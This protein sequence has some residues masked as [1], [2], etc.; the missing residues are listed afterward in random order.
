MSEKSDINVKA[1]AGLSRLNLTEEESS[2]FQEEISTIL[3]YI[4]AIH[5][6]DVEGVEPTAHAT[7]VTNVNRDDEVGDTQD[8]E[9][10]MDNA[11]ASEDNMVRVPV[12]IDG[13]GH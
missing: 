5:N 13:G 6:V 11:P 9:V 4:D 3:S 2:R 1:I 8:V 12:V 10:T 7:L